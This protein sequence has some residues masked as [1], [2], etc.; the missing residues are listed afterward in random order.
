MRG[1][2]STNSC[3]GEPYVWDEPAAHLRDFG[4]AVT[5]QAA[6]WGRRELQELAECSAPFVLVTDAGR[7]V[8]FL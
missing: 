5:L 3:Q 6:V 2:C 1:L 8:G 4:W 7:A